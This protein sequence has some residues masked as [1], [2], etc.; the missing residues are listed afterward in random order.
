M[1]PNIIKT[2]QKTLEEIAKAND[3]SYLALFGSYARGDQKKNSDID[4][5]VNFKNPVDFFELYDIE[6]KFSSILGRKIDLV[7]TNGLSKYVKPYIVDDLKIIY[8]TKG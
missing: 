6:Q 1:I 3:I 8:E 2:H 5:L 7:T 4:L